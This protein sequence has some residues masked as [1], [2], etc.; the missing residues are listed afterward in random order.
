VHHRPV[1]TELID[2]HPK[3]W[4]GRGEVERKTDSWVHWFNATRLH[5]SIGY[6][7]PTEYEHAYHQR[8]TLAPSTPEVA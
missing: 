2:R 7:A 3:S 8:T 5:S 4:S 1:Q 6:L